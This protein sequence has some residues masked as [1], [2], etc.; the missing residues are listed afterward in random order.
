MAKHIT[1]TISNN[2]YW[3]INKHLHRQLGLRTTLLLQHFIDLQTKVFHGNEFFQ[4]Y[5]QI[6]KELMLTEYHIKD[7]I[8]KLKEVGVITVEKKGM[9]AK[10]HYFVL[11]NRV[12]E[13]LS[14]DIEKTPVKADE[15]FY[16]NQPTGEIMYTSQD[17]KKSPSKSIDEH[18]TYKRNKNK[19]KEEKEIIKKAVAVAQEEISERNILNR[20]LDDLIQYEDN[21]K[22]RRSWNDILDYGGLDKV[23]DK[24]DFDSS[25]R[26]N[27]NRRIESVRIFSN[28]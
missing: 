7:S 1:R 14:L 5:K 2:A 21:L 28:G 27:W 26:T 24:L 22:F 23:F 9:P 3:Q 13:L 15:L 20:L 8:K 18:L 12:E 10:N 25:Q 17:S 6:N 19:R 11:L 4:S 16:V